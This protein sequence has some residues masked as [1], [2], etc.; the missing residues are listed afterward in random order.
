M[1]VFAAT[2]HVADP[3]DHSPVR[4][5]FALSPRWLDRDGEHQPVKC[6]RAED[7]RR[8]GSEIHRA[9]I[10]TQT[11]PPLPRDVFWFDGA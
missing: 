5:C 9:V 1:N 2:F 10:F 8:L 11:E 6:T 7:H 4:R 3:L